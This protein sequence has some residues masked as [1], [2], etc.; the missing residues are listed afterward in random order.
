L[1]Y[2]TH[3]TADLGSLMILDSAHIQ[4]SDAQFVNK[5]RAQ[6]GELPIEPL[7]TTP[8][9]ENVAGMFQGVNYGEAFEPIPGVVAR[10][11]EAGHILGSAGVSLE[12]DEKGKRLDYGFRVILADINCRFCVIPFCRMQLII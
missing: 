9:A 1:I 5:K 2:A 3:A 8:D 10:L 12:I 11:Y 7:Y 6:R 4:E